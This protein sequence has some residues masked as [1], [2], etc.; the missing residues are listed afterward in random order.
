VHDSDS[1]L[2]TL[3]NTNGH[4]IVC[5]VR[6]ALGGSTSSGSAAPANLRRGGSRRTGAVVA[7]VNCRQLGILR[8][9]DVT[10][11]ESKRPVGE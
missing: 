11:R 7:V 10:H 5:V 2:W 1:V 9:Q 3:L 6:F 4:R 8:R